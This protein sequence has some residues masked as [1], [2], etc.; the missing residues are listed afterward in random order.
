MR[1]NDDKASLTATVASLQLNFEKH[2]SMR[3]LDPLIEEERRMAENLR[4]G[5][6]TLLDMHNPAELGSLCGSLGL[7]DECEYG[8]HA[9]KKAGVMRHIAEEGARIGSSLKAHA[10]ALNL[11]WDG[12]LFEY[13]RAE[14]Q[15]LRTTRGIDPRAWTLQLWR[16]RASSA[17]GGSSA[18]QPFYLPR[19]LHHRSLQPR[20]ADLEGLLRGVA[21]KESAVK[22][23]EAKVRKEADY[24]HVVCYLAEASNLRQYEADARQYLVHELESARARIDHYHS[25][26]ELT[27]NQLIELESAYDESTSALADRL[28]VAE[29]SAQFSLENHA[30]EASAEKQHTATLLRAFLSSPGPVNSNH[31]PPGS[32]TDVAVLCSLASAK[33]EVE[34]CSLERRAMASEASFAAIYSWHGTARAECAV[35]AARVADT[36]LK[37]R[38]LYVRLVGIQDCTAWDDVTTKARVD[39]LNAELSR[40]T[41]T[42]HALEQNAAR[43]APLLW[44]LLCVLDCRVSSLAAQAIVELALAPSI[45][46]AWQQIERWNMDREEVQLRTYEALRGP[47]PKLS[48]KKAK[49]RTGQKPKGTRAVVNK[50]NTRRKKGRISGT[51]VQAVNAAKKRKPAKTK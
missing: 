14:G 16:R 29:A 11:I 51:T 13:L 7:K 15:P 50:K 10:K 25:S 19:Q 28:A 36:E 39:D 8:T 3:L 20:A 46:I 49:K 22:H 40:V 9:E 44:P 26:L 5:L 23:V 45:E 30:V 32:E 48:K 6:S 34:L 27:A 47:T 21:L 38:T 17:F 4:H 24:R 12:I 37:C 41:D 35:E 42:V 1:L 31:E 43:A 18:F 2:A 33:R